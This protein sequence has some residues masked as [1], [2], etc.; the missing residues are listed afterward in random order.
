MPSINCSVNK[1]FLPAHAEELPS[2]AERAGALFLS[3]DVEPEEGE[4]TSDAAP[5]VVILI[6]SSG[7]MMA[8]GKIDV[9][10]DAAKQFINNLHT[11]DNISVISFSEGSELICRGADKKRGAEEK[12]LS[13]ELLDKDV[14]TEDKEEMVEKVDNIKARG[15][16]AL[17]GALI[18]AKREI[19]ATTVPED[20]RVDRVILLSDGR[21]TVGKSSTEEFTNLARDFSEDEISVVCGGI[22]GDYNEDILITLAE[23][24]RKGKW[25]HLKDTDDI[26]DL[27]QTELDRIQDTT[28]IKPDL[29]IMPVQGVELGEIYQ[30]EPEVSR[31]EDIGIAEGNYILPMADLVAGEKQTYVAQ[32]FYP[33]R[34]PGECRMAQV[35]LSG[36]QQEDIIVTYVDDQDVYQG[37]DDERP[38]H[39][40]LTTRASLEGRDVIDGDESKKDTVIK[41]TTEVIDESGD[42][43]LIDRATQI[44]ETVMDKD[45]VVLSAEEKKEK[46]GTLST[47]V[48][49]E[50]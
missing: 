11:V 26:S 2:E 41:M 50:D 4:K 3:I 24:S 10:K 15:G 38:R 18:D 16:T 23:Q 21:P 13:D 46:K 47:T 5:N 28:M 44:K 8:E 25:R 31:C 33:S 20:E 17:F 32:I 39:Q 1:E 40:F 29:K 27:F 48:I 45:T 30:A 12:G 37:E 49:K 6:D 22:G 42:E 9:A 19:L 14:V 36:G 7:S 35:S 43:E 34:P